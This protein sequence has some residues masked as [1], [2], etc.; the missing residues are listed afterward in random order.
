MHRRKICFILI[1]RRSLPSARGELL[2]AARQRFQ[3]RG[4]RV[5]ASPLL[6][7]SYLKSCLNAGDKPHF[8]PL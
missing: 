7:R 6:Q 1:S 8:V 3:A 5:L 4:Y 2:A